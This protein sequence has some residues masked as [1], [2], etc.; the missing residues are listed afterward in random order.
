[1]K[2]FEMPQEKLIGLAELIEQVKRELLPTTSDQETAV[3]LLS[4]DTIELELQVTVRKEGKAGLKVYVFEA[5]GGGSRDDVQKVKVTLSPLLSK[6]MRL[7]LLHKKL[8]PEQWREL[9]EQNVEALTKGSD[10]EP[11][12]NLYDG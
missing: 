4:V 10:D 7:R 3:P 1:L 12:G 2:G 11:L 9:L 8:R 6:E 5:G